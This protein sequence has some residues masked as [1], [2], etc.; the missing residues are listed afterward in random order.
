MERD[1]SKILTKRE[2]QMALLVAKGMSNTEIALALG[3]KRHTVENTLLRAY[4]RSGM[5]RIQIAVSIHQM[6]N[7]EAAAN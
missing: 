3:L 1:L 4:N 2:F 5:N 6:L 7:Q